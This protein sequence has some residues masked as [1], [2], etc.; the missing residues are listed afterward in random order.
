MLG[1]QVEH[2]IVLLGQDFNRAAPNIARQIEL[3]RMHGEQT[4]FALVKRY[5]E[6]P[7]AGRI[8]G[9]IVDARAAGP[10]QDTGRLAAIVAGVILLI[11]DTGSDPDLGRVLEDGVNQQIDR[12]EE[13]I[14]GRIGFDGLL[15][16]DDIDMQ[17]LKG[18]IP[19]R[20]AAA[21]AAGCDIILNCWANMAEQR[22]IAERFPDMSD[23]STRRLDCVHK[24]M[25]EQP[26][27][28]DMG[29]LLAKR[30]ALLALTEQLA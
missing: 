30:D 3:V 20:G 19:D 2:A 11:T 21:L 23:T 10:I 17:A 26:D 7:M 18:T 4:R 12:L 9:A 25:G 6:E 28:I 27:A 29:D 14:R 22:Q 1:R 8:A 24:A 15:L 5:G 16:T 13:I